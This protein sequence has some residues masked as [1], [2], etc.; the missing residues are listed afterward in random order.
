MMPTSSIRCFDLDDDDDDDPEGEHLH[1][2]LY[3][4]YNAAGASLSFV[5]YTQMHT[6]FA[7][8]MEASIFKWRSVDSTRIEE[9]A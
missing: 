1:I 8:S 6:L 2:E 7:P 3:W 4:Y 5:V 9:M